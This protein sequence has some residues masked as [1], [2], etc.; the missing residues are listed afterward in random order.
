MR[1]ACSDGE[2]AQNPKTFNVKCPNREKQ[3]EKKSKSKSSFL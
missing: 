1:V 3:K 2:T